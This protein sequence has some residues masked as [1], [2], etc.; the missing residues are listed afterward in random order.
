MQHQ[1]QSILWTKKAIFMLLQQSNTLP[2]LSGLNYEVFP[3]I[4]TIKAKKTRKTNWIC[5][6][7]GRMSSKEISID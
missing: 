4:S 5:L 7:I 6:I 3:L 2:Q 1:T